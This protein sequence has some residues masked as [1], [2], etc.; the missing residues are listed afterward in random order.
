M[1]VSK[2]CLSMSSLDKTRELRAQ[3]KAL[4]GDVCECGEIARFKLGPCW[5]CLARERIK[6][7]KKEELKEI[8]EG[9]ENA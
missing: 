8:V 2:V 3:A 6:M 9:F 4:L 1:V 5:Y 7:M